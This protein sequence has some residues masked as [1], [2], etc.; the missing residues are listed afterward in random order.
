LG[1]SIVQ[2]ICRV[3]GWFVSLLPRTD[4]GLI[5]RLSIPI[6]AQD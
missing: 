5:A 2:E 6:A 3:Q 1:L 4:G